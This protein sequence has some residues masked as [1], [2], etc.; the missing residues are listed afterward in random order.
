MPR[1]GITALPEIWPGSKLRYIKNTVH[2]A[3]Y[4]IF[5]Q[6]FFRQDI[7]NAVDLYRQKYPTQKVDMRPHVVIRELSR[8]SFHLSKA[9][10]SYR[11]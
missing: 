6:S 8:I 9:W 4:Y 5:H 3:S 2:V 1:Y 7:N 10:S 11:Y